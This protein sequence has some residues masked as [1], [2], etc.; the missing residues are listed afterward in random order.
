[1]GYTVSKP[2]RDKIV[3]LISRSDHT[4]VFVPE[5]PDCGAT[6]RVEDVLL[7]V[8]QSGDAAEGWTCTAYSTWGDFMSG[9]NPTTITLWVTELAGDAGFH[10]GDVVLAHHV[11]EVAVGGND[12]G[13]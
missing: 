2:T 11:V 5:K 12:Y 3:R 6:S 13:A 9:T 8:V 10:A 1:M 7:A 4:P